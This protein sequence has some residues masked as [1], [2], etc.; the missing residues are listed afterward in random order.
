MKCAN[1]IEV[2]AHNLEEEIY[3]IID[4]IER[5]DFTVISCDTEFPGVAIKP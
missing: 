2:W 4:L 1:I 3:K 5:Q